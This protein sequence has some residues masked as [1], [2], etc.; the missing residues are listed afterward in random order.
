MICCRRDKKENCIIRLINLEMQHIYSHVIIGIYPNL[1]QVYVII[2]C[3]G[4]HN[5]TKL[6][7]DMQQKYLPAF[8]IVKE[9]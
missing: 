1:A 5:A 6:L 7:E 8:R 4:I 2:M 9:P 3:F